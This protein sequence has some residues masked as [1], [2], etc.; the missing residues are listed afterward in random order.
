MISVIVPVYNTER[1][2]R[3][4]VESILNQTYSDL[5]ILLVDDGSTDAS[6]EICDEYAAKDN[7]VKVFHI[8]N[9]GVA[10]AR[11][12]G[13]KEA[14]GEYVGFVDSDDWA[15]P[16]MYEV[17][18]A[19]I[20][21]AKADIGACGMWYS[22]ATK[23]EP[24]KNVCNQIFYGNEIPA[25]LILNKLKVFVSNKLFKRS[26]WES[27]S[28][29]EGHFYE[30]VF[31][32][33]RVLLKAQTLVSTSKVLYHY[34]QRSGSIVTVRSMN[35][36]ADYWAAYYDRYEILSQIPEIRNNSAVLN[37]LEEQMANAAARIWW[38]I[39]DVPKKTRNQDC[40]KSVSNSV[41]KHFPLFGKPG[42]RSYLR[43]SVFLSR[44]AC[45]PSYTVAHI[46]NSL[47]RKI[48][49]REQVY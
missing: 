34:R 36:L 3:Q 42:W 10:S 33:H 6:G 15:E 8:E 47:Y 27:V 35:N 28:F 25:A 48:R 29:P 14:T 1:L 5:E 26:V 44:Y 37:K 30:D 41:K 18:L 39:Y 46:M 24:A 13:L 31:V 2:L 38:W 11:N 16:D 45:T 49:K 9:R 20:E 17:L 22:F 12:V 32:L 4:C 19:E 23:E 43:L 7:R 21:R 40:L